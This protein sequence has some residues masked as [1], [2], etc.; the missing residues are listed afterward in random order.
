MNTKGT[1]LLIPLLLFTSCN[2][3]VSTTLTPVSINSLKEGLMTLATL[4]NY[5][6]DYVSNNET[7]FSYI[8]TEKSIGIDS[9]N[10][11]YI[12]TLIEDE[13]GIYELK[14]HNGFKPGE[15]KKD[16]D[17]NNIKDLWNCELS[18]NLYG[19]NIDYINSISDN[20]TSI[21][22]TDKKYKI[23]IIQ[24]LGYTTD[25]YVLLNSI[26]STYQ[27][28]KIIFEISFE[29][30]DP[31]TF[32]ASS[33][34]Q[35]TNNSVERFLSEGGKAFVPNSDLLDFRRVMCASNFSRKIYDFNSESY[36]GIEL[37]NPHYFYYETTG[38]N[39]GQGSLEMN[40]KA[41]TEH[42]QDLYGCYPFVL[43]GSL[44]K[45]F[46]NPSFYSTPNYTKPIIEEMFHYPIYM[47]LWNNLQFI[48]EGV[49]E[50]SSYE[51][52]GNA[53]HISNPYYIMDFAINFSID[54]SFPFKDFVPT[55]LG[56]NMDFYDEQDYASEVTFMYCF[57]YNKK[58][59]VMPIPLYNFGAS[60][61]DILDEI[62]EL[63]N[64]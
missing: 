24:T 5:R 33:F 15:Y 61:I 8:F 28:N 64:D 43:T 2:Q 54:Q 42:P 12:N 14:Y 47:S 26:T 34:N 36:T 11:E 48:E 30:N 20:E 27:N 35:A 17:S 6:I 4:K 19:K 16:V 22:I 9:T 52:I 38:T 31:Y 29:N 49:V 10:N 55:G 45:G 58:D 60:N 59:Y 37:F 39:F 56:I 63:Y 40:Q 57:K 1:L 50:G 44:D 32:I 41:N 7:V 53:Y 46:T 51:V 18:H 13:N 25:D 23:S 3:P 21:K 62:Y